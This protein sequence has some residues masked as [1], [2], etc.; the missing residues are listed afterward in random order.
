[1]EQW[2]ANL[3][4]LKGNIKIFKRIGHFIEEMKPKEIET[5]IIRVARLI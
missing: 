1:M 2:I 5:E 4:Q 3:F